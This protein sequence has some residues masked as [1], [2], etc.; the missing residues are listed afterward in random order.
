VSTSETPLPGDPF[1]VRDVLVVGGGVMGVGIV[2]AFLLAGCAVT[3]IDASLALTEQARDRVREV[4]EGGV[5]RGK[6]DA[7]TARD[8]LAR[9]TIGDE[10]EAVGRTDIAIESVP[11]RLE[12]KRSVL[13]RMEKTRPGVL[14]TN[15]G[16]LSIAELAETLDD[17]TS[18]GGMHFFNPVW[19]RPLVEVV[20]GPQTAPVIIGR[21]IAAARLLGKHAIAVQDAPGFASSRLGIALGLEAMRMVEEGVASVPDID[22]AVVL[23]YGHPIGPL[24]LTDR[25]GL[26]IRLDVARHLA[27]AIGPRFEPP[28]ILERQVAEGSLGQKSGQGFYEWVDGKPRRSRF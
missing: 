26:D 4:L 11:E 22:T 13:Q 6:T 10:V 5:A 21:V 20:A 9:L 3:M 27:A 25:V 14:V 23:G 28:Q 12:L 8:A 16:A 2:Q 17:P 7:T 24:E 15:T 1:E 18:F 19:A